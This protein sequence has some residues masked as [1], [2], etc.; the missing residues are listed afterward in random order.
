MQKNLCLLLTLTVY[1]SVDS[2]PTGLGSLEFDNLD[3]DLADLKYE[4]EE[5]DLDDFSR[6]LDE[7]D[8][9]NDEKANVKTSGYKK[10]AASSKGSTNKHNVQDI[11]K[12]RKTAGLHDRGAY[13]DNEAYAQAEGFAGT[14]VGVKANE[15]RKYRK[16][17]KTRG[18]HRVHHKDEYKKDK[19]FYEDDIANGAIDKVGAKGHGYKIKAGSGFNK[20]HFHHDRLKGIVGKSG[21]SDKGVSDKEFS[22]YA[23]SQG[24]DGLFSNES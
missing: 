23:N 14:A 16:G 3:T 13:D 8:T 11:K 2:A 19:V 5:E 24:F 10:K 15:D 17:T 18:F 9:E 22:G 21:Y 12:F 4:V 20:G 7:A 1:W 6:L